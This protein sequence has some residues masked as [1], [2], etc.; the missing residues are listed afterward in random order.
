[1]ALA[2]IAGAGGAL[3]AFSADRLISITELGGIRLR[4]TPIWV[5]A[6][7]EIG[8]MLMVIGAWLG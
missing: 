8:L 7:L 3:L 5:N 4:Y 2:G 1:M 6:F